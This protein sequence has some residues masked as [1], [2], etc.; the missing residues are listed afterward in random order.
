MP[1]SENAS[2]LQTFFARFRTAPLCGIHLYKEGGEPLDFDVNSFFLRYFE[3]GIDF[4]IAVPSF[5]ALR[6]VIRVA[7][8]EIKEA[9]LSVASLSE[10]DA[11]SIDERLSLYYVHN[12]NEPGEGYPSKDEGEA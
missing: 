4:S 3:T 2:Q 7:H 1:L 11:M 10:Y 8:E 5:V 9:W 6:R 12:F